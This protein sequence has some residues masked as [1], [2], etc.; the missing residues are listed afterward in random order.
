MGNDVKSINYLG[1]W[2]TQFGLLSLGFDKLGDEVK[3][4]QNPCKHLLE[5]YV[6]ANKL[7]EEDETFREQAKQRFNLL[8]TGK[9]KNEV[10][11]WR[12]FRELSI[13]EYR[14][15]YKRLGI[16]FDHYHS[17][18]MYSSLALN[19]IERLEK[20]NLIET[21]PNGAKVFNPFKDQNE[22]SQNKQSIVTLMKSDGSSLYLS[23][24]VA[25]AV[26]RKEK[27]QFDEM[28]YV[29]DSSQ[30]IHFNNIKNILKAAN[31]DWH[32]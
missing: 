4:N 1:D 7:C 22:A 12:I 16:D 17:E 30:I 31:Y 27:Y 14:L 3:L 26:D 15:T 13:D 2:G 28:Y 20:L 18:S 19:I 10:K 5:I 29:V 21:Q 6:K 8:E 11:K 25:A 9:D 24:D 23:R 32:R